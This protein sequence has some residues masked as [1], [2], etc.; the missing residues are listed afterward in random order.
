MLQAERMRIR[1]L[2]T[3]RIILLIATALVL[4]FIFV[5]S[6]LPQSI[7]AEESGWFREKIL[8]PIASFFGIEPLSHAAVRKLA[9]V[10]EYT[11]LAALLVLTLRNQI[12]KSFGLGFTAA[13]LDES[14]QAL[15]G[16]GS[17]LTDVWIDLCGVALGTLIGFLIWKAYC[18]RRN[19]SKNTQ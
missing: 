16:R 14:L 7:S 11:V 12:V 17:Q 15:T 9:H 8:N 3:K 5:Q 18:R 10:F 2:S 1:R 4:L 13:F 6:L 19:T